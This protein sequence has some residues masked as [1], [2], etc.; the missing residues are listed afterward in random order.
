MVSN[1]AELALFLN[2]K[3]LFFEKLR[4]VDKLILPNEKIIRY[5][6]MIAYYLLDQDIGRA[7]KEIKSL[8]TFI[9]TNPIALE[10]FTWDFS[11]MEDYDRYKNLTGEAKDLFNKVLKLLKKVMTPEERQNFFSNKV[12]T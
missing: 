8:L 1:L 4:V 2:D 10:Q 9:G 7:E 6:L 3:A 5:Y 11:D 12:N